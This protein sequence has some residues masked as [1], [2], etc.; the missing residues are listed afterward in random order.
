[1][2]EATTPDSIA[3]GCALYWKPLK[4]RSSDSLIIV[5]YWTACVNSLS[6]S[7]VGSSLLISRYATSRK[8]LFS[9]SWS[10]GIPRCSSTPW[11]PSMYVMRLSQA[12]VAMKSGSNVY[13]PWSRVIF[14]MFSTSGP[15]VPLLTSTF[16]FL[17]VARFVSSN[18]FSAICGSRVG[19]AELHERA[20][21]IKQRAGAGGTRRVDRLLDDLDELTRLRFLVRVQ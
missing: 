14:A 12:A 1:A 9:A 20:A 11:S 7:L 5:W 17:P 16:A 19:R 18:F 3:I 15:S 21:S 6:C 13:T 2:I 8:L 10:I 4:N